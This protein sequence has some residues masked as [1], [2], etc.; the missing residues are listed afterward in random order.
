MWLI[1]TKV[2]LHEVSVT[3]GDFGY[4]MYAIWLIWSQRPLAL[5]PMQ[6]IPETRRGDYIRRLR[7]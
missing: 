3:L 2:Y 5:Y 1:K 4:E 7:F 6:V